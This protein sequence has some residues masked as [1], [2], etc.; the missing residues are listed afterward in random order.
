MKTYKGSRVW[1]QFAIFPLT[2]TSLVFAVVSEPDTATQTFLLKKYF[3][4][5]GTLTARRTKEEMKNHQGI[6]E[7]ARTNP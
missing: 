6:K 2:G 4:I 1:F 7:S 5:I 3:L